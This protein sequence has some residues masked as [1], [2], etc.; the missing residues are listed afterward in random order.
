MTV[1]VQIKKSGKFVGSPHSREEGFDRPVWPLG[2]VESHA[3]HF[4]SRSEAK[5]AIRT[6]SP[7]V[8]VSDYTFRKV[9]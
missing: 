9:R 5:E 4:A 6:F 1:L 7:D 8:K 3:H 2:V